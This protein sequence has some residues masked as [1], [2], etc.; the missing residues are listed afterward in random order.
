MA[1]GRDSRA[2]AIAGRNDA[3]R[4]RPIDAEEYE[5]LDFH[6]GA[7]FEELP[8][9]NDGIMRIYTLWQQREACGIQ[10]I[11]PDDMSIALQLVFLISQ[12]KRPGMMNEIRNA[13]LIATV[14]DNPDVPLIPVSY[15]HLTLP[16]TERV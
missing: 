8:K 6:C 13:A 2:R 12:L 5:A 4:E 10:A 9:P 1:T 16:T 3:A 11:M 15:T 7:T 14:G